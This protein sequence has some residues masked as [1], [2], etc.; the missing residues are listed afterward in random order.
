MKQLHG[1]WKP[2]VYCKV[3]HL[4][5]SKN[6]NNQPYS[7][8]KVT[9]KGREMLKCVGNIQGRVWGD[10]KDSEFVF[11]F[12]FHDPQDHFTC[13]FFL[14]DVALP[15]IWVRCCT[16]VSLILFTSK[17]AFE[18][19]LPYL[20]LKPGWEFIKGRCLL[21]FLL[22]PQRLT[23]CGVYSGQSVEYVSDTYLNGHYSWIS[24]QG[25]G[26]LIST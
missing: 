1:L 11:P 22:Y 4:W 21:L 23:L 16:S 13:K 8:R 25:A 19:Q 12:G 26:I 17:T 6:N 14:M 20:S 9:R 15:P 7:Q 5:N 2:F 10:L 3:M 24:F 18:F